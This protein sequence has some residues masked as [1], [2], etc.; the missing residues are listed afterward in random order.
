MLVTFGVLWFLFKVGERFRMDKQQQALG[1]GWREFYA[2]STGT[3]SVAAVQMAP[4]IPS[5]AFFFSPCFFEGRAWRACPKNPENQEMGFSKRPGFSTSNGE[6]DGTDRTFFFA[7]QEAAA[8]LA[9]LPLTKSRI[10]NP[11]VLPHLWLFLEREGPGTPRYRWIKRMSL[12]VS[13]L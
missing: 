9:L 6:H 7:I 4:G 11:K 8:R 5:K 12:H 10:S 2:E 1:W 3:E 13:K